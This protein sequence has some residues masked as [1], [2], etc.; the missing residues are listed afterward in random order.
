MMRKLILCLCSV[1][2]LMSLTVE[3]KAQPTVFSA[4]GDYA[5]A[6]GSEFVK[7]SAT[8]VQATVG[9]GLIPEPAS[10]VLLGSGLVGL[11]GS[12]ARRNK[13]RK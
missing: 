6:A 13:G 3:S 4:V 11:I 7:S 1:V 8:Q 12:R 5:R 9:V 10:M 2:I